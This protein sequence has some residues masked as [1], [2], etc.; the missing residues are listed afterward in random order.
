MFTISFTPFP[1]SPLPDVAVFPDIIHLHRWILAYDASY[2]AV[3]D[4]GGITLPV[5]FGQYTCTD[6]ETVNGTHNVYIRV[7][8]EPQTHEKVPFSYLTWAVVMRMP[9]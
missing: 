2:T 9:S 4:C 1:P 8:K 6:L 3:R 5:K 7:Y